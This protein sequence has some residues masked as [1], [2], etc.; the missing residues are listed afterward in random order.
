MSE[1][2]SGF[3]TQFGIAGIEGNIMAVTWYES[4]TAEDLRRIAGKEGLKHAEKY[5]LQ[6]LIDILEE[7]QEEK[8]DERLQNNDIMRLKGK[9]YDIFRDNPFRCCDELFELPE[10][11][12][13]TKI[14][15]LLR[16][17]FWAFTYWD[18]HQLDL[19]KVKETN[20]D[21]ELFLRIYELADPD[22]A[23]DTAVSSFEIPVQ[24]SDTSWYINLPNPDRG[25]VVDLFCDCMKN[26]GEIFLMARSNSVESP[27]GYWLEHVDGLRSKDRELELFMAGLTDNSGNVSDN[28]LVD[29]ILSDA[30]ARNGL[31][32]Y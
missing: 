22:N 1:D 11:Y 29:K 30:G 31:E 25:Y 27:G 20:P 21:L 15:L 32:H 10:V 4:L 13:D 19:L 17:P 14:V 28:P 24:E 26:S 12:A 3:S 2:S 7:I 8:I 18:I 16:D 23:I 5:D 9:M 6:E